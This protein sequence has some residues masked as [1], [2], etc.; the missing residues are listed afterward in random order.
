[1]AAWLVFYGDQDPASFVTV[2]V[3]LITAAQ[4]LRP[5]A[6]IS[7]KL[8]AADAAA[9]RLLETLALEAESQPPGSK[10][11]EI[12]LTRHTGEITFENVTFFYLRAEKPALNQ[13]DLRIPFGTLNVIVGPNGSGKTTLVSLLPQLYFPDE[14]R[15][16]I[17]GTDI[18]DVSMAS[19]RNQIALV[20]QENHLFQGT[21]SENISYG[22]K[23]VL[24]QQIEAAAQAAYAHDFICALP[25]K[26]ETELGELG[27][28]LSAG[29]KQRLAIARALLRN[30][31]VLILDE[32]TSHI[33]AESESKIRAL[34]QS[35]RNKRTI[36]MTTHCKEDTLNADMVIV[37]DQGRIVDSG[38]HHKLI[39]RCSIY[40]E[41]I[42]MDSAVSTD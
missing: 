3:A 9:E 31:S 23:D 18:R 2:L 5:L 17:D 20:P 16:L 7:N 36:L 19:L 4:G 33:D 11:S 27:I 42:S 21:L 26:Y 29:Q 13:I 34:L 15:V 8:S 28:G 32:A 22:M 39:G 40:R 10:K 1:V 38:K 41:L 25:N 37:M 14:G 6:D 24:P 12:I 35:I 30:P